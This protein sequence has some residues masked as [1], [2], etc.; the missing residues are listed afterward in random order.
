MG[1]RFDE[2]ERVERRLLRLSDEA[3][4]DLRLCQIDVRVRIFGLQGNRLLVDLCGLGEPFLQVVQQSQRL[5]GVE[6][7]GVLAQDLL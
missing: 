3:E 1:V 6:N 7:S 2:V 5:I 4:L